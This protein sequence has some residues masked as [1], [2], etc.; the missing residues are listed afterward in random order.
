MDRDRDGGG[1]L[2]PRSF[3]RSSGAATTAISLMMVQLSR[4][5]AHLRRRT[6]G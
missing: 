4:I 3:G 1:G 6:T 5:G 2:R